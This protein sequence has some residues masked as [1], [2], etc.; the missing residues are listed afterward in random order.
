MIKPI[1]SYI[2][3]KPDE[4]KDTTEFG[5]IIAQKEKEQKSTG[6]VIS[7]GQ[8]VED[9]KPGDKVIFEKWGGEEI[10]YEKVTYKLLESSK[11]LALIE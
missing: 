6:E 1:G 2:L 8:Y 10:E 3:V 5:I 11:I 9:I 7:C 4:D